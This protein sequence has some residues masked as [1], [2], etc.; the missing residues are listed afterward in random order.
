MHDTSFPA[1]VP[2]PCTRL[3]LSLLLASVATSAQTFGP[4]EGGVPLGRGTIWTSGGIGANSSGGVSL[5]TD[6][7]APMNRMEGA[8]W[9]HYRPDILGAAT[10]QLALA[11]P[12]DD[13]RLFISRYEFLTTMV[14]PLDDR[15]AFQSIWIVSMGKRNYNVDTAADAPPQLQASNTIG[16]GVLGSVGTRLGGILGLRLTGGGRWSWWLQASKSENL[17]WTWEVEPAVSMSL[18]R[19]WPRSDRLTRA[20]ELDLRVPMEYTPNQVD[21]FATDGDRYLPTSWQTGIHVGM[22]VVF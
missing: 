19:I 3:W 14:W 5:G 12:N 1:V 22:S 2:R 13:T 7:V 9:Y 15:S 20:M 10:Y 8:I 21:L 18:H 4:P 17:E 16:S 6:D 11:F